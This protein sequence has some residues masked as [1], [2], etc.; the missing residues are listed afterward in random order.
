MGSS[1]DAY[2]EMADLGA[3]WP[4][5][6]FS[7]PLALD[8]GTASRILDGLGQADV[9]PGYVGL[10]K[11]LAAAS[12]PAFATELE[13]EA[14]VIAAFVAEPAQTVELPIQTVQLPSQTV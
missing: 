9:P 4:R 6:R 12:A 10:A 1:D 2:S 13:G 8:E 7:D 5:H 14:T 3:S 11:A